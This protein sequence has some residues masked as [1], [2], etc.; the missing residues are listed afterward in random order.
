MYW[1]S[2]LQQYVQ[3]FFACKCLAAGGNFLAI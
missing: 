2:P 3:Y 1:C